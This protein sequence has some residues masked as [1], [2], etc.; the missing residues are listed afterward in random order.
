MFD[1][2]GFMLSECID[3][4]I[5]LSI[6]VDEEGNAHCPKCNKVLVRLEDGSLYCKVCRVR[7][8]EKK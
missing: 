7:Y 8:L 5:I 2:T 3:E 6:L 1:P 4:A